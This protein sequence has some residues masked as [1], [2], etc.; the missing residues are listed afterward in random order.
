[1]YDVKAHISEGNLTNTCIGSHLHKHSNILWPW[2][3]QSDK[4]WPSKVP[5]QTLSVFPFLPELETACQQ[6]PAVRQ[7]D[8]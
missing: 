2:S 8:I 7:Y 4:C 5:D 1:M 3:H 6:G